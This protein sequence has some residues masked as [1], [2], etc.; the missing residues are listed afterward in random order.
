MP[1]IELLYDREAP[2]EV[3]LLGKG[4]SLDKWDGSETNGRVVVAINE[5]M[6]KKEC[7]YGIYSDE[8]MRALSPPTNVSIIR[9]SFLKHSHG[10]CEQFV[11]DRAEYGAQTCSTASIAIIMLG[12]WGVKRILAVGF[13]AYD[14]PIG[15]VYA[16]CVSGMISSRSSSDFSFVN[17]TIEDA[18]RAS[19]VD[20]EFWHRQLATK[21]SESMKA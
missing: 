14:T 20:V 15:P 4:P 5:A 21:S 11:Y 12:V 1:P 2:E 7:D 9:P 19:G 3:I 13:D 18:I 16:D 17:E 10:D 8:A 6:T